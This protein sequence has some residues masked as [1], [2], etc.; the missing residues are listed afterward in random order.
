[1]LQLGGVCVCVGGGGG[2]WGVPEV[3][4]DSVTLPPTK[5]S[6]TCRRE[7]HNIQINDTEDYRGHTHMHVCACILAPLPPLL[8][9]FS[10]KAQLTHKH[11]MWICAEVWSHH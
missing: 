5:K 10:P 8:C 3:S 9:V 1:M 7:G 2:E 6:R 4:A 11:T